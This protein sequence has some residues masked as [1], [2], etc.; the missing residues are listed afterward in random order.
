MIC[1]LIL[2]KRLFP[3]LLTVH[4]FRI[5]AWGR[6]LGGCRQGK[7]GLNN[8]PHNRYLP[9]GKLIITNTFIYE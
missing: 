1:I 3:T 7:T 9:Q 4:G 5:V 6:K 2:R 8:K